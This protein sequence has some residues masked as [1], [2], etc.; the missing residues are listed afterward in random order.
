MTRLADLVLRH[1]LVVVLLW[2]AVAL[3]GGLTAG[4]TVDRLRYEFGLPGA[5]AYATNT[6]LQAD[7]GGGGLVD[8]VVLTAP[9]AGA[10]GAAAFEAAAQRVAARTR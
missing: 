7:F 9:T 5:A 8:P 10:A 4:R 6:R 1:R 3:A 2:L